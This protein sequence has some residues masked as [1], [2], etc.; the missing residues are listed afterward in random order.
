M[1]LIKYED[2]TDFQKW[3]FFYISK[4]KFAP[5]D[6]EGVMPKMCLT[7][8]MKI[9]VENYEEE[10]NKLIVEATDL[11]N[12]GLLKVTNVHKSQ[13]EFVLTDKGELYLLQKM[14]VWQMH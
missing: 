3:L 13:G 2:L 5:V 8:R 7:V 4:E 14:I 9:D 11:T 1:A 10:T 6:L 12:D